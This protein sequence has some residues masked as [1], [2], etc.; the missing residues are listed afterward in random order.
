MQSCPVCQPCWTQ[1]VPS[2][3][4]G[5]KCLGKLT[6]AHTSSGEPPDS[7]STGA[8]VVAALA[9][10]V[11]TAGCTLA[12]TIGDLEKTRLIPHKSWV[13]GTLRS[14]VEKDEAMWGPGALPLLESRVGCLGFCGFTLLLNLKHKNGNKEWEWRSRIT[15]VVSYLHDLG[16]SIRGTSWGQPASL[17]GWFATIVAVSHSWQYVYSGWMSLHRYLGSQI[18]NVRHL[19]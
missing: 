12:T 5:W 10:V 18:L 2:E 6:W 4:T 3:A 11:L 19:C 9:L 1:S 8:S 13:H 14:Q 16:L 17:F 7:S 15:Q